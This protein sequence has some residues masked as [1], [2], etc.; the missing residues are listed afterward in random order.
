M[1]FPDCITQPSQLQGSQSLGIRCRSLVSYPISQAANCPRAVDKS[2]ERLR[3]SSKRTNLIV[4]PTLAL[5]TTL[6]ERLFFLHCYF[7]M[8]V[9]SLFLGRKNYPIPY[10]LKRIFSYI[11]LSFVLYKL[12]VFLDTNMLVNTIYLVVFLLVVFVLERSKKEI[13]SEPKLFD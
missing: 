2:G 10:D 13:I 12:S 4:W 3:K 1:H 8:M 11:F 9:A 6:K 5:P 7:G